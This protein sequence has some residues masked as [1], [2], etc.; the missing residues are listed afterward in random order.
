MFVFF[1]TEQPFMKPFDHFRII[2]RD[3]ATGDCYQTIWM[4]YS[5][6]EM[7][8]RYKEALEKVII[9]EIAIFY[10]E[11]T[12]KKEVVLRDFIIEEKFACDEIH[13]S[14]RTSLDESSL[15]SQSCD[16]QHPVVPISNE[17]ELM[18]MDSNHPPPPATEHPLLPPQ[19]SC[20]PPPAKRVNRGVCTDEPRQ[21]PTKEDLFEIM[22]EQ[23]E[24]LDNLP[25]GVLLS[26]PKFASTPLQNLPRLL[27]N[28]DSDPDDVRSSFS[29]VESEKE[30]TPRS[31]C[32]IQFEHIEH[33]DIKM[34]V[35]ND[36]NDYNEVM[37]GDEEYGFADEDEEKK[38]VPAGPTSSFSCNII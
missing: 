33:P 6:P 26:N 24:S 16:P 37:E 8:S 20:P 14:G 27:Q 15:T 25:F 19:E 2:I 23:N 29:D 1:A 21:G 18:I 3:E 12:V 31:S 38:F 34:E 9:A 35:E 4:T 32:E 13:L 5:M 28:E 17:N 22:S 10:S 30:N 11:P 36:N 7:R